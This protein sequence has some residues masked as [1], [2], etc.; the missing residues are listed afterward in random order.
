MSADPPGVG[1]GPPP[2]RRPRAIPR[3][4]RTAVVVA[5]T[6]AV[7]WAANVM[8]ILWMAGA[9]REPSGPTVLSFEGGCVVER[10]DVVMYPTET[11]R[12]RR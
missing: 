6:A 3:A 7:V 1:L 2:A 5:A 8:F 12:D 9:L 10:A 4:I 11:R